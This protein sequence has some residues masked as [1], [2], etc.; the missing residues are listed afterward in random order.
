[1]ARVP[2][3]LVKSYQSDVVHVWHLH[4]EKTVSSLYI[5][6]WQCLICVI[7]LYY[8]YY[9]YYFFKIIIIIIIILL[10]YMHL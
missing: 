7:N 8:Y 1:M 9:Y 4:I 10:L 3:L 5:V 2:M 6:C